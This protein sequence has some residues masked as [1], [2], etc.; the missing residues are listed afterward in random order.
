VARVERWDNIVRS[1]EE[2]DY[3][4]TLRALDVSDVLLVQFRAGRVIVYRSRSALV[5]DYDLALTLAM[6]ETLSDPPPAVPPDDVALPDLAESSPEKPAVMTQA[7]PSVPT[8]PAPR[9]TPSVVEMS[10]H[11]AGRVAL[12]FGL[13]GAI[14]G[15]AMTAL[16]FVRS[17]Y[18][19]A[20]PILSAALTGIA[21]AIATRFVLRS[22]WRDT[23]IMAGLGFLAVLACEQLIDPRNARST[24]FFG[25]KMLV[26]LV[27][28]AGGALV[29]KPLRHWMAWVLTLG[30]SALSLGIGLALIGRGTL[31]LMLVLAFVFVLP[32]AVLFATIGYSLA[33]DPTD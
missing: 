19:P 24:Q 2:T 22:T 20:R 32:V 1:L 3:G 6:Y 31:P 26:P 28:L 33:R 5:Q 12:W 23:T 17:G 29:L 11:N 30:A 21:F 27:V 15:A 13:I 18:Y 9:F 16:L 8:P 25:Y 14:A 7:A 4:P 10:S